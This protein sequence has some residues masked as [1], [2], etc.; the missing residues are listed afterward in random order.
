MA[1]SLPRRPA[2]TREEMSAL[3]RSHAAYT[4]AR[5]YEYR[6][7]AMDADYRSDGEAALGA[8]HLAWESALLW[9]EIERFAC[10]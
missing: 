4:M 9:I 5:A 8:A 7:A 10:R 6:A 1:S 2:P 3:L